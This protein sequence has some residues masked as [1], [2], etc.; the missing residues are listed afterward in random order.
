M[1]LLFVT[2]PFVVRSV[3]PVLIELDREMEEAAASLGASSRDGLPADRPAQPRP[4]DPV[5]RGAR[6]RAR[7]RRVRLGRPHLR[8][9][10]RSRPRS[11]RSSSSGSIES[12][13]VASARGGVGRAARCSRSSCWSRSAAWRFGHGGAPPMVVDRRARIGLRVVALGYLAA[14]LLVPV[15]I[16]FYRTFEHGF[17]VRVGLDHDAGRDPRVLADARDR[18]DRRAAEHRL[19]RHHGAGARPRAASAA[20]SLLRRSSTCR[21]RSRR[22]S[23]ASRWCSSTGATAGSA[24]GSPT[25]ASRSSSPCPGMVLATIFVSPAV[26][27]ARGRARAAR[28]RRR[29]GAGGRDARRL[30]LADLRGGSRCR[31]SAAGIAYGVVLSMARAIGEFGAVSVVSRQDRRPDRDADAARREP[32]PEL[33]RRRGVRRLGAARA[34]RARDAARDDQAPT[35]EGPGVIARR[36]T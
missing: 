33:R 22:S 6:V 16:V 18:A 26:R 8:A 17:G 29:A 20:R 27:G 24:A 21:S 31:R 7:G 32:L 13:A 1:A 9:T 30:A 2:L 25:T 35:P 19:R 10:S 36:P 34:H 4:G 3:Q 11:R 14:L 23:S 28:D 5:G 15:G 12:D